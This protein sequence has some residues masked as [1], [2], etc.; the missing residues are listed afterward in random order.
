MLNNFI[1]AQ[2]KD[3]FLD[4]LEAGN[5]LD[6]AIVFI[7]DT[8]EIWNHGHYFGREDAAVINSK[9]DKSDIKTINGQPILGGGDLTISQSK[10]S[11]VNHG[12]SDTNFTLTSGVL[13]KWSDINNLTLNIPE[14]V[15]GTCEEYS[16]VFSTVDG[17]SLTIPAKF[18]WQNSIIP[19]FEPNKEYELNI[20]DGKVLCSAFNAPPPS[21]VF[22]TYIENDGS[23]Y[24][25]TDIMIDSNMYGVSYKAASLLDKGSTH[26]VLAGA[27][28]TT[29]VTASTSC[30]CWF[31]NTGNRDIYWNGSNNKIGSYSSGTIYEDS[32]TGVQNNIAPGYPL[33]IFAGNDAG[34]ITYKGKFRIFNIKLLD[35]N[36]NA[37]I[38]LRPFRK[39]SGVIGLLDIVNNKFY[40]SVN[41]NL[42][43]VE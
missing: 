10:I 31:L 35:I 23:D 39:D 1:Y 3:L 20:R 14:D 30:M 4:N 17:F 21:G 34:A 27:R 33:T 37:I 5:I 13:H 24:I 40:T 25:L 9:V 7:E 32:K 18:R 12:S 29:G 38:D 15:D 42:I 41:G 26:Y 6:E 11:I 22:L 16:V 43:G 2:T 8:K 28:S 19:T 36:N